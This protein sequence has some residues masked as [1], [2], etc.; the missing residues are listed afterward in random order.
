MK[1]YVLEVSWGCPSDK[2]PTH[3]LFQWDQA[4]ALDIVG[5]NVI[6]LA[7]DMRS[8]RKWRKWGINSF[9]KDGIPVY[10]Y[11]FPYGP[12]SPRIKY[13]IQG[14]GFAGCMEQITAKYGRPRCVHF[15]GVMEAISGMDY[16]LKNSVPYVITE[17]ITP[18][19]E[20]EEVHAGMTKAYSHADRIICVSNALARDIRKAYGANTD[21][22][23]PNIVD[24]SVFEYCGYSGNADGYRFVS[25]AGLN[26]GKGMDVLLN[27][28][29]LVKNKPVSE[30]T[31]R[32]PVLTIMGDGD[33]MQNLT[34]LRDSLGLSDQ[35]EFTGAYVRSEFAARLKNTDCFVLASRSETFGIVYAEAM[36]AGVPVISTKCGG[37]EDFVDDTNGLFVPV[38]DT[39][40]LAA[41]MLKMMETSAEYDRGAIS[42]ECHRK[43][44]SET[45]GKSL[46]GVIDEAVGS[47]ENKTR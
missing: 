47:A 36:A 29:A 37:P 20:G 12:F 10:E 46:A 3:G 9:A 31:K 33:Q 35:V 14:K 7:L 2:Y 17:H 24:L 45:I 42:S 41:A 15:H 16:C 39:E 28:F 34:A 25:A 27:A 5:E 21:A 4:R 8:F 30:G 44:S 22:V 13:R 43:F 23:I 26:S 6:F 19:S 11:N 40:A 1:D 32:M 18:V 38:D